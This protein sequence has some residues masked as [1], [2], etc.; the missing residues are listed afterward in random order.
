MCDFYLWGKECIHSAAF[1]PLET[2]I[3]NVTVAITEGDHHM[4]QNLLHCT[5]VWNA[6]RHGHNSNLYFF[7]F[8]H[9]NLF[10][11]SSSS[12]HAQGIPFLHLFVWLLLVCCLGHLALVLHSSKRRKEALCSSKD[13]ALSWKVTGV[14][15]LSVFSYLGISAYSKVIA[16]LSMTR[17]YMVSYNC[18]T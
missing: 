3:Q 14:M 6:F 7:S 13:T 10:Y 16:E 17:G 8:W 18:S 12:Y 1:K 9:H 2:E 15:E 4:S 11:I 5:V